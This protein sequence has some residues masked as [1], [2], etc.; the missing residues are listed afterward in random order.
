MPGREEKVSSLYEGI[1]GY[2]FVETG[3][4]Q[5]LINVSSDFITS[6]ELANK[7]DSKKFDFG[8]YTFRKAS[9]QLI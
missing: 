4:K 9:Y 5:L 3:G 2:Y 7:V 6:R 8:K 1:A